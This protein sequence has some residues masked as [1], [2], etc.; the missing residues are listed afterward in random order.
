MTAR[1]AQGLVV[2]MWVP[3]AENLEQFINRDR[4]QEYGSQWCPNNHVVT[5]STTKDECHN[6]GRAYS[7][8]YPCQHRHYQRTLFTEK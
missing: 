5:D 2:P 6:G 1:R 8:G 7:G 4:T 3:Q